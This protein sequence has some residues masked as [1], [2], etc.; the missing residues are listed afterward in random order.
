MASKAN[1]DENF[2][3]VILIKSLSD[4]KVI[5][6]QRGDNK[7][8]GSKFY[9]LNFQACWCS[10][11]YSFIIKINSFFNIHTYLLTSASVEKIPFSNTVSLLSKR[12][13]NLST[14]SLNYGL[15]KTKN[16]R[17]SLCRSKFNWWVNYKL[18]LLK[19]SSCYSK[20]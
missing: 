16:I 15:K 9:Y 17:H 10:L 8:S 1:S 13:F 2:D 14:I 4:S 3:F 18:Y 11:Y 7:L 19:R 5:V 12:G 6:F 20:L